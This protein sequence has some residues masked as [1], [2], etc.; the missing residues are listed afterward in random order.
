MKPRA[1]RSFRSVKKT[2]SGHDLPESSARKDNGADVFQRVDLK[3][4]A[5]TGYDHRADVQTLKKRDA[6][7]EITK[8]ESDRIKRTL[9]ESSFHDIA[10]KENIP[11]RT[12]QPCSPCSL[13]SC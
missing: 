2:F 10:G 5:G 9:S 13:R 8:E 4:I 6:K 1:T 7:G 11:C 12:M 3:G